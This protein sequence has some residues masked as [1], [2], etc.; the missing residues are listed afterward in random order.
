MQQQRAASRLDVRLSEEESEQI[1]NPPALAWTRSPYFLCGLHVR[2][3]AC[4]VAEV[5]VAAQNRPA[6]EGLNWHELA[7]ALP[8]NAVLPEELGPQTI[9]RAATYCIACMLRWG[10]A[11][12]RGAAEKS[13]TRSAEGAG[14]LK[15]RDVWPWRK[16]QKKQPEV[17]ARVCEALRKAGRSQTERTVRE[18]ATKDKWSPHDER[19]DTDARVKIVE[20]AP[21]LVSLRRHKVVE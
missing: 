11:Q 9:I 16:S 8:R 15:E 18:W 6:V 13:A 5:L 14:T 12:R 4:Q 7:G 20:K 10:G 19:C 21:V 3:Y 1:K 2:I 17:V